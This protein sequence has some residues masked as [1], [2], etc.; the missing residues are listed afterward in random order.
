MS[1]KPKFIK[2]PIFSAVLFLVL[3]TA[4]IGY[5]AYSLITNQSAT[6]ASTTSSTKVTFAPA[7]KDKAE[8]QFYVMS[9]CPYGNQAEDI[10]KP[11]HDLLGAKADIRP[12]YIF[13]K[14]P[15]LVEYCKSRTGDIA[16]CAK[17]VEG[18][19]FK[20]EKE[21]VAQVTADNKECNNE[22]N[23]IKAQNGAFYGSLH[24]R[25]EAN[26]DVREICAYNQAANKNDW[27]AFIDNV[28]K[29]CTSQNADTCWEEQAKKANLDTAKIT[30]CFNTEAIDLIEKE[31]ALT[32]SNN[33]QGSPTLMVNGVAFPPENSYTQD[34]KG[35]VTIGKKII[36]QDKFRS[37]DALKE[38]ICAGFKKAPKE[39]STVLADLVAAAGSQPSADAA[40]CATN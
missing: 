32:N 26:Q 33:I 19:Y 15:N 10:I 4:A 5:S 29:N 36:T 38:A 11:V 22:K 24:G 37:P 16:Q 18:G 3:F 35:T 28:N 40:G 13:D 8:L 27:W 7:K 9:F 6:Q 31:L 30:Q 17:Y 34:G 2:V 39:C 12:Q 20:D 14:I 1:D 25:V 23:F 21:C